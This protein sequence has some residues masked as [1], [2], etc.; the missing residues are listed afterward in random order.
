MLDLIVSLYGILCAVGFFHIYL[1]LENVVD[2][3]LPL[4]N[5]KCFYYSESFKK[6]HL[7]WMTPKQ[8]NKNTK[9]IE[10]TTIMPTA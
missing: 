2:R 1:G 5:R 8:E 3:F 6:G 4:L 9:F 10:E 7:A